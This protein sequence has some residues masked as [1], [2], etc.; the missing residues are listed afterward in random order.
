MVKGAAR[1][2]DHVARASPE[3]T[4]E[5]LSALR[6]VVPEAFTEGK[7]DVE[8][9][10]AVLGTHVQHGTERYSFT[11]AGKRDSILTL[12]RPS[13]ATLAPD[14]KS[15]VDFDR[16]QHLFIEG[17]NLEVLKLLYKPYFGSVKMI[18]IDPP[19]NTGNLGTARVFP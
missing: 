6:Q 5:R 11:W 17:D 9:L 14:K 8:K 1:K 12:Q 15:S 4:V 19:Y 18:Y 13:T 10:Q 7:P 2:V 16:T 3:I